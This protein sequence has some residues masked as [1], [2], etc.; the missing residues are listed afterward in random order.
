[1]KPRPFA[2]FAPRTLDD[3]LALLA[4][5]GTRALPLAGGQSLVQRLNMRE[6]RPEALVDLNRI[7]ALAGLRRGT[8]GALIIGAMTRQQRLVTDAEVRAANPALTRIASA[9]AFPAIRVRGTLGGSVANA[10]PGAQLPLLLTVLDAQATIARLGSRRV[11]PVSSLFCGPLATTLAPEELLIELAIPAL[12][13]AAGYALG[14]FRRGHSGPP[15]VAVVSVLALDE[16]GA[17]RS[18]RLGVSGATEIPLRLRDEEALLVGQ[19]ATPEVFAAVARGVDER[20]GVGDPVLAD[21]ELRRR[22]MRALLARSLMEAA[23]LARQR[24]RQEAPS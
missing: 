17:V 4:E 10:E 11:A 7:P 23:D 5:H 6:L 13:P 15:L 12:A 20:V 22:A 2:Y 18:A 16:A 21:A 1:V 19:P 3:A 9:V 24:G 8:E 14:E